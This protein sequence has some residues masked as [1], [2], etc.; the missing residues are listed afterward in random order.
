MES[1]AGVGL[2]QDDDPSIGRRALAV[3]AVVVAVVVAAILLFA[4]DSGYRVTAEFINAGQLVNGNEVRVAGTAVGSVDEIDVSQD[5]TAD[6]T[7]T[8]DG[9]YAPLRRG[10]EAIIKQT[11]LSGI[12]NRYVD[13][14]LGPAGGEEIEDGGRIDSS[15]TETAVELDQVFDLFTKE[16]RRSLQDFIKGQ[17]DVAVRD[18]RQRGQADRR[19]RPL[20]QR[21]E[22]LLD[23]H[24]D[25]RLVVVGQL[26]VGDRAHAAAAD[27]DV[28]VAHELARVL[29][30]ERVLVT[31]AATE[32]EQPG[33]DRDGEDQREGGEGAA[34]AH[35]I[36]S[37]PW[38][39]P[40]RNWRTNWLSELNSSSAGPDSSIRPFHSTAM[41]SATRLADMM[42]WVMTT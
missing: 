19:L 6:V 13:L 32:E 5:G 33:E 35:S 22:R 40:A 26:D 21:R 36:P 8:V 12:A 29:E 42:S 31:R 7:F 38:E 15:H 4:G 28:V 3:G 24:R 16:T 30:H 23:L 34:D 41:Y 25:G 1:A 37:G 27:L 14:K 11:S 10:T 17:G 20:A 18:A 2:R 39:A 9:D